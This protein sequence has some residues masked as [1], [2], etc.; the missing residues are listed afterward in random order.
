MMQNTQPNQPV[1]PL[2][3]NTQPNQPVNPMTQNT[4]PMQPIR[5]PQDTRPIPPV[6]S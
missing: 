1:N 2:T 5:D 6:Q 3:Q 4:Q